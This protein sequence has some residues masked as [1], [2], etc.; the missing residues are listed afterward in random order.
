MSVLLQFANVQMRRKITNYTKTWNV[1]Q[2]TQNV[3]KKYRTCICS[4]DCRCSEMKAQFHCLFPSFS[5]YTLELIEF[6]LDGASEV[7]G[8]GVCSQERWR[9]TGGGEEVGKRGELNVE[10]MMVVKV[11]WE[12]VHRKLYPIQF[13]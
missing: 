13:H 6:L 10:G 3:H 8:R 2:D 4:L 9:F 7:C 11:G 1:H 12:G 5:R